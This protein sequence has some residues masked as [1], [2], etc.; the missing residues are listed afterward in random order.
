MGHLCCFKLLILLE[1][2]GT[3]PSAWLSS[4]SSF[5]PSLCVLGNK[6]DYIK[7][8]MQQL[9]DISLANEE[10][11]Q[12]FSVQTKAWGQQF[13]IST[14]R[15]ERNLFVLMT[16]RLNFSEKR[17]TLVD[18]FVVLWVAVCRFR[19]PAWQQMH[20]RVHIPVLLELMSSEIEDE[21]GSRTFCSPPSS[22]STWSFPTCPGS[23]WP[24]ARHCSCRMKTDGTAY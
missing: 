5:P 20:T 21:D 17:M 23:H 16:N 14:A 10:R 12:H 15:P 8:I 18:T 6:S 9:N 24:A 19:P 3:R 2:T 13:S 7:G 11:N 1:L 4:S 22:S